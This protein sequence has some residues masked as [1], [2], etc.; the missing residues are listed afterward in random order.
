MV[1]D[2]FV[3][4]DGDHF[5]HCV[6]RGIGHIDPHSAVID[7]IGTVIYSVALIFL[8]H[9]YLRRRLPAAAHPGRTNLVFLILIRQ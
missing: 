6:A 7:F 5:G 8:N 3:A 9:V 1:R 4:A 2:L